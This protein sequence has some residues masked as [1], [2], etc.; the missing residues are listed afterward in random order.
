MQQVRPPARK[1]PAAHFKHRVLIS[2]KWPKCR[3]AKGECIS[4]AQVQYGAQVWEHEPG[5][6]CSSEPRPWDLAALH[7]RNSATESGCPKLPLEVAALTLE[8]FSKHKKHVN[9][10]FL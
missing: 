9:H 6:N 1:Q 2:R 4:L 7:S 3:E 10:A 8:I 5:A